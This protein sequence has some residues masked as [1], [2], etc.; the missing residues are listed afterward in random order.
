MSLNDKIIALY[1][2]VVRNPDI[3]LPV[4]PTELLNEFHALQ[5]ALDHKDWQIQCLE[6]QIAQL[7]QRDRPLHRRSK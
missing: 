5:Q 6:R 1:G 3:K 2:F 4:F 7:K